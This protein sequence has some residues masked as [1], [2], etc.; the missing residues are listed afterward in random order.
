MAG[1]EIAGSTPYLK[2][3]PCPK[4]GYVRKAADANPAW[5]CPGCGIAYLKYRPVP[6]RLHERVAEHGRAL[7]GVAADDRSTWSLVAA[8][9]LAIAIARLFGM[10]LRDL[11]LVYWLQ[12][13]IIGAAYFIRMLCLKN[14]STEGF[15][16]GD[17]EVP[18]TSAG[19]LF[20]AMFFAVHYGFFHFVYLVFLAGDFPGHAAAPAASPLAGLFLCGLVFALH[21]IFSTAKKIALDRQR[22][23]NLGT[24]MFTPYLRILPMHLTIIFGGMLGAGTLS[25]LLFVG[26]KT[27]A[28]V[29]MHVTEQHLTEKSLQDIFPNAKPPSISF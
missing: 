4:C 3:M 22:C 23:P 2:G 6:L 10:T 13:V 15:K 1:G 7:A 21:Q 9:L 5:Q 14:F 16:R 20:T 18:E 24:L 17:S 27:I 26:L 19:K 11:M 28:D 8:N 25:W 12:S 29:V